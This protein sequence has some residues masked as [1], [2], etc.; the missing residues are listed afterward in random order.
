MGDDSM[1]LSSSPRSFYY[2]KYKM[3]I[4][5]KEWR[6]TIETNEKYLSNE[7]DKAEIPSRTYKIAVA[8]RRYVDLS[9]SVLLA[10]H[11]QVTAADIIQERVDMISNRKFPIQDDYLEKYLTDDVAGVC[12]LNL[13]ATLDV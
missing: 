6:R 13:T 11:H 3:I 2:I 12:K 4:Y 7:L 9:L 10:W 5:K 8:G 1:M